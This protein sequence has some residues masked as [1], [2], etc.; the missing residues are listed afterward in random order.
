MTSRFAVRGQPGCPD[1]VTPY[2]RAGQGSPLVLL[3]GATMSWRAW[4]PV[5][6]FLVGR[7][8]VFVPTLAGHRG[9]P[10]LPDGAEPGLDAVVDVLCAQLDEA[11]IDTA[12]LV[13]NSLGGWLAFE[14]ARR[15]R[16]RSVLG[17]SPAGTWQ[18]RRDVLRLLWMFRLGYAAVGSPRLT[19]LAEH[20]VLR[21]AVL[22]R[23]VARPGRVSVEELRDMVADMAA[24]ELLPALLAGPGRPQ[25]LAEFD[26]ALCPVR[27]AWAERDRVIPFRRYGRPMREV[28]RGAEFGLLRG[29]GHVP[30]SDDPRLVARTILELTTAVDAVWGVEPATGRR[31][32]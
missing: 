15:G 9:G 5:L 29:V 4:R 6:P 3:H 32:A 26:V 12:H 31:S 13:G 8:D 30:M 1:A 28:V 24:C 27:I 18:A 25:P 21:R 14:L 19:A 22:S 2:H 7:H 16:A 23:V 17:L 11:G 10:R 20:G